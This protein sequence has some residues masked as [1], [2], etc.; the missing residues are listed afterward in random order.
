MEQ[1]FNNNPHQG[2]NPYMNPTA[3]PEMLHANT[4]FASNPTNKP[5][6]QPKATKATKAKTTNKRASSKQ[7]GNNTKNTAAN[8]SIKP[9]NESLDEKKVL[10]TLN[11]L[12]Y[13]FLECYKVS[14]ENLNCK[15]VG[16]PG[17][18]DLDELVKKRQVPNPFVGVE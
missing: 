3:M 16:G 14:E 6:E 11:E 1:D 15:R 10:E 18:Q 17:I 7:Q 12:D 13:D 5:E 2:F 8:S 4:I 9:L